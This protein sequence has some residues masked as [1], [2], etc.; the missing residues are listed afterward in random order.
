M[1]IFNV[2]RSQNAIQKITVDK[3]VKNKEHLYT[4][5]GM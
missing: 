4:V 5:G 1:F 2:T 3:D